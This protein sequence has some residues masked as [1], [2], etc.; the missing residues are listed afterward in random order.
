MH[1]VIVRKSMWLI[2]RR[3]IGGK[4]EENNWYWIFSLEY[5]YIYIIIFVIGWYNIK[6]T[7]TRMH[8][9]EIYIEI[10]L[11]M[12]HVGIILHYKWIATNWMRIVL[13]QNHIA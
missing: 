13:Y 3:V 5:H 10:V 4:C 9:T 12:Y 2:G 6:K 1:I 7:E 8:I 11:Y